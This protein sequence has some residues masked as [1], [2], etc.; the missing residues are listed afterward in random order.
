MQLQSARPAAPFTLDPLADALI[1]AAGR[2]ILLTRGEVRILHLLMTHAY[3]TLTYH[4]LLRILR[5]DDDARA[6][7][8]LV[9]YISRLRRKIEPDTRRPRHIITVRGQG[10]S[11]RH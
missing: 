9:A 11:F 7:N 1:D 3:Q 10:Y 2:S 6:R 5:R 8:L 4:D